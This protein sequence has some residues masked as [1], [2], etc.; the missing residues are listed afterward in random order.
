[1][2][3][4]RV[5][6]GVGSVR[7]LGEGG[8]RERRGEQRGEGEEAGEKGGNHSSTQTDLSHGWAKNQ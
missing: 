1:M 4:E 5:T 8:V 6:G 3:S 2:L 7:G